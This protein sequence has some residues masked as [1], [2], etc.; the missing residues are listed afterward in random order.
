[1][2]DELKIV[3]GLVHGT[4]LPIDG[5]VLRFI[6]RRDWGLS[7]CEFKEDTMRGLEK[8]VDEMQSNAD[9]QYARWSRSVLFA[10]WS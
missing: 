4:G 8:I 5:H 3:T 2:K 1:M 9:K 7:L 10:G 6:K